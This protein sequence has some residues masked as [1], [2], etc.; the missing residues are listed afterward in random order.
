MKIL[1]LLNKKSLSIFFVLLVIFSTNLR[2]EEDPV[3]IWD[4][5]TKVEE[6]NSS[7]ILENND[8]GETNIEIDNNLNSSIDT[9]DSNLLYEK[10]NIVGLYD[11]EENGL[12][13]D[14]W[15]NSNG[16][17]I[18]LILSK[19]NKM[20]LSK[21]SKEILDIALLTNS[22]F[23]QENITEEEFVDFKL[24]YLISNNNKELIKL[25]LIKNESNVYNSKLI[26]FY[27]DDFI[28]NSDLENA[29]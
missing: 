15:S 1:K 9:I 10:V 24:N 27:I 3:D 21:D 16:N 11:P 26:K 14:M 7:E 19:I 28:K 22:Y 25:Y 13:I 17:E 29:C 2:S 4:L 20:N 8:S 5:E 6:N 18:K 12:N 23:P